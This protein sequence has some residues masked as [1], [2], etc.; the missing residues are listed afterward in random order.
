MRCSTLYSLLIFLGII[1]CLA[2]S[3][4]CIKNTA[5]PNEYKKKN[6]GG[7]KDKRCLRQEA[8]HHEV[9]YHH[10]GHYII[11]GTVIEPDG[12]GFKPGALHGDGK[13]YKYYK[14]V[15]DPREIDKYYKDKKE[16]LKKESPD[17]K[18]THVHNDFLI[19]SQKNDGRPQ[20]DTPSKE[21]DKQPED[22]KPSKKI[23]RPEA[24]IAFEK[25]NPPGLNNPYATFDR[26]EANTP[27]RK[28]DRLPE[29]DNPYA[30]WK[31]RQNKRA[32]ESKKKRGVIE[33]KSF[34]GNRHGQEWPYPWNTDEANAIKKVNVTIEQNGVDPIAINVIIRNNSKMNVT[35]VTRNSP[36]DKDAFKLGHFRVYPD[37][38]RIN[39]A[40]EREGYTWYERPRG[41]MSRPSDPRRMY[42]QSDFTHLR[43][44]ETVKQTIIVPSGTKEQNEQWINM[45][46]LA[47]N[48]TMRVE[49]K[50]YGIGV[51]GNGPPRW[52]R[53]GDFGFVS[54]TIDLQIP[55]PERE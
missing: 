9:H 54:N 2:Q 55:Q 28:K 41:R 29:E 46:R 6:K 10:G 22:D 11:N 14:I 42:L 36:V 19:P 5:S 44:N 7:K 25:F 13:K 8:W 27:Y 32:V 12:E 21:I 47:K 34:I 40:P 3:T 24:E 35:I 37:D 1:V 48:V 31:A 51:R 33:S 52:S 15:K 23:H 18:I 39:F 26:P 4:P 20:A 16:K 45:I 17:R 30:S 38:T 43:P 53:D 50:W 49:G